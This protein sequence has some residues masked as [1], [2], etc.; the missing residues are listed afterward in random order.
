MDTAQLDALIELLRDDPNLCDQVLKAPSQEA[1]ARV[2]EQ[3][4]FRFGGSAIPDKQLLS[5]SLGLSA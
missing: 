1:R 2:L 3:L 5:E 4:G